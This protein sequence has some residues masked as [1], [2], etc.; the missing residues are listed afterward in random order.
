MAQFALLVVMLKV[1]FLQSYPNEKQSR[2]SATRAAY[3]A[4]GYSWRSRGTMTII[5]NCGDEP[6]A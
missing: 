5:D 3:S 4:S 6:A 1:L 2:L